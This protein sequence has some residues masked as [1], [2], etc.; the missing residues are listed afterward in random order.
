MK[1]GILTFHRAHNYGAVLQCYALKE[2]LRNMGHDVYVIDYRQPDIESFYRFHSVISFQ[3]VRSRNL[4]RFL[5]SLIIA[6]YRDI[7]R[8]ILR[9]K[10][11]RIFNDFQHRRLNLSEKCL[12]SIPEDYDRYVIG[13]DMLWAYDVESGKYDS[14]YLGEFMHN[15]GSKIIGYAI[16]GTPDSFRRLGVEQGFRF[17]ENFDSI[18][19]R[20]KT[21]AEIVRSYSNKEIACCIDPTLLT[22]KELWMDFMREKWSKKKYVVTY[23]LRISGKDRQ[24]IDSKIKRFANNNDLEI[25]NIDASNSLTPV[26]VEEFV[27]IIGNA[28][29]VVT[30]S[31][32]GVVFSLIFE[33]P[34]H[35]ICLYDSHDARYVDILK[36]IGADELIAD[37]S[38]T[39]CIPQIDYKALNERIN[40]FKSES[41]EFLRRSI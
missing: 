32:H 11:K 18:S 8:F 5:A 35:A 13:S 21:L 28:Q 1:I 12:E 14:F 10:Y 29:Y 39:P 33:R 7:R 26:D 16:S 31:F 23:Y 6:P 38:F 36:T 41:L 37:I 19:I 40:S 22:T 15:P 24:N 9:G 2:V 4:I 17:L 30:D 27:S 3:N 34:L 20:E 25:I